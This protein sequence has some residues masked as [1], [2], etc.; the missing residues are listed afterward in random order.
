MKRW[1]TKKEIS[2]KEGEKNGGVEEKE[3]KALIKAN[4]SLGKFRS[5]KWIESPLLKKSIKVQKSPR[6]GNQTQMKTFVRK[7]K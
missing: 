4:P 5:E 1:D 3:P 6:R 7:A 2:R